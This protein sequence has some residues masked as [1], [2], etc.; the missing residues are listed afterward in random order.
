MEDEF[1]K[2][3]KKVRKPMTEKQKAARLANLAAGRKKRMEM[4]KQR[5]SLTDTQ[6]EYDLSSESPSDSDINSEDF[7]IKKKSRRSV[8]KAPLLKKDRELLSERDFRK[9]DNLRHEVNEIKSV[10]M[11][12]A[13]MQ[14]KTS[15]RSA[16]KRSER[17]SGGTKIVVLP[18]NNPPTRSQPNDTLMETLRKS[19]NL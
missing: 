2:V 10:V 13:N 4:V 19:L 6:Q 5:A 16:K 8:K 9:D 18:Q 7:I 3:P 11:E 17:K 14:K 12:L 15:M 1:E